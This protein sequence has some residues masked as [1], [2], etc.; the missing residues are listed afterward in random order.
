MQCSIKLAIIASTGVEWRLR[1]I[2]KR[3]Q[4]V[5]RPWL[6]LLAAG[7]ALIWSADVDA[8]NQPDVRQYLVTVTSAEDVDVVRQSL[9]PVTDKTTRYGPKVLMVVTR[10]ASEFEELAKRDAKVALIEPLALPVVP[11]LNTPSSKQYALNSLLT[12][13][14]PKLTS[15]YG[16]SGRGITVGVWDDGA[17]LARHIE[18]DDRVQLKM[19]GEPADHATHVAGTIA[20][21]G[22]EKEA[23]GMAPGARIL[24]FSMLDD[25]ASMRTALGGAGAP[26]VTNHSY[27]YPRG[28]KYDPGSGAWCWWGDLRVSDREDHMFGKYNTLSHAIDELAAQFPA[29]TIF[30]AAGNARGISNNPKAAKYWDG[31]YYTLATGYTTKTPLPPLNDRKNGYDTLE[32]YGVAKNVIV[33]GAINDA[34][35][36]ATVIHPD[37]VKV[38]DFSSWGPADDGR[39]K[40]DVVANGA[41]VLSPAVS[42]VGGKYSLDG[43][44]YKNGTSQATPAAAGIGALLAELSQKKHNKSLRSDE[45]KAALVHT[46]VSPHEGPSYQ[47][48]WGAVD[49]EA[50]GALV[51]GDKGRIVSAVL[52]S[53][54]A[55]SVKARAMPAQGRPRVSLVWIDPPAPAN[56][57]GIDD[58]STALALDLDLVLIDPTGRKFYPWSLDPDKP[59]QSATRS[60]PNKR[61]NVERVDVPDGAASAGE[62]T[63]EVRGPNA[64]AN[65]Q[66]VL[67][68]TGFE[69]K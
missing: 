39:I 19:G 53:G 2:R 52:P 61:D 16:L 33:V 11:P 18:F 1:W 47:I 24:S 38:T 54:Q 62:W 4:R 10:K 6:C 65:R 68:V 37:L 42:V 46:A 29:T 23:V 32:G 26:Q 20:A 64:A 21:V 34:P 69:L 51:A 12:H 22:K 13:N 60:G 43:Y 28:W 59:S 50:A 44:A 31:R 30:V 5:I 27:V 58:R 35:L 40:P 17:V 67:A 25:I 48:G 66:F 41:Q 14:V 3:G 7:L 36:G 45:M 55:Y 49:A 9:A 8:Q 63:V 15:A 56:A 57:S